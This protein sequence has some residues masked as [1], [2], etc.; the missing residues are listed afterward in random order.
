MDARQ[1]LSDPQSAPAS[2]HSL[3]VE[4]LK[5]RQGAVGRISPSGYDH[6]PGSRMNIHMPTLHQWIISGACQSRSVACR[7]RPKVTDWLR[8]EPTLDAI[9]YGHFYGH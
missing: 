9:H 2:G 6:G 7:N 3:R 5:S 4:P 8:M 1:V